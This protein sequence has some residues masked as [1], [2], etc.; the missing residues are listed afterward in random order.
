VIDQWILYDLD[1]GKVTR[2]GIGDRAV[3]FQCAHSLEDAP[4]DVWLRGEPLPIAE[5]VLY[6]LAEYE[7]PQKAVVAMANAVYRVRTAS[8]A[9][10]CGV[11]P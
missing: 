4:L 3:G 9:T 6:L 8:A 11:S 2:W 1:A 7:W 10:C 5:R